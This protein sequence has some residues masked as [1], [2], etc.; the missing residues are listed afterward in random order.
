[1]ISGSPDIEVQGAFRALADPTRRDI[2][3]ML[4]EQDMTIAQVSDRFD[5]TR[6]AVKKHLTILQQGDLISVHPSGRERINHLEPLGL[7]TVSDWLSYFNRFW[8]ERLAALQSAVERQEKSK[9][10]TDK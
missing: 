1:M 10:K 4:A 2:L 5:I 8:D 6:A 9:R 3:L 7:K